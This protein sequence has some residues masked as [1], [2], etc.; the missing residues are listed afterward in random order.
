MY[1]DGKFG[2]ENNSN[3][4]LKTEEIFIYLFIFGF[5]ILFLFKY[6]IGIQS[7]IS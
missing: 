4:F 6:I 7:Y 2:G 3:F 1:L 5:V